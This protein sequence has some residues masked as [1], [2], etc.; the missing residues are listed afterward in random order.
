MVAQIGQGTHHSAGHE[1]EIVWAEQIRK[2]VPSA[3]QVRFTGSGTESTLLAVRL[4]RAHTGKTTIVKLEGH[5]HG[6]NDYLLKGEKAPFHNQI[7]PGIPDAVLDTIDVLPANNLS[8]LEARLAR[9]DVAGIILEPS[10]GSWGTLPLDGGYLPKVRELA[11]THG[12][13]LI[14][15]EVITGFRWS[16]GGAQAR[17]GLRPDLTTM[18]KI[19]AGGLPG[20]AIAGKTEV[21]QHLAFKDE[22]GWNTE[23]KIRHQGT[24]NSS[25][26]VAAAA[27]ACLRRCAD[28]SVQRHC[29]EMAARLRVGFNTVLEQ[30]GVAGFVWGDSSVFHI[31]LGQNCANRT[32]GDLR[33]PEGV[34]TEDLKKS[35]TTPQ[36]GALHIGMLLEGIDLFAGGGMLSVAHT[37]ADVDT[38]IAA[39]DRV[40]ERLQDEGIVGAAAES[41]VDRAEAE[42]LAAL[43]RVQ[44]I[45]KDVPISSYDFIA[46]KQ[47]EIDHELEREKRWETGGA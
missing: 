7:H 36:H 1:G 12:V 18:A 16:P 43:R 30:R 29:D 41:N 34:A 46:E 4:A 25:P 14:F 17:Y 35:N 27:V 37:A 38:A 21:M 11:T 20:G 3:E 6:W 33:R 24:F 45:S 23:K 8:V 5:F 47:R 42:R 2:M 13:V 39:F 19:V 44:E 26:L 22:P 32:A 31:S 40:L 10:G 15:D 9:G 28:G